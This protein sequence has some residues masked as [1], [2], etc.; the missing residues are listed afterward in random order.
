MAQPAQAIPSYTGTFKIKKGIEYKGSDFNLPDLP[1]NDFI[2]MISEYDVNVS[3]NRTIMFKA[4]TGYS[5]HTDDD[6]T[7]MFDRDCTIAVGTIF[8]VS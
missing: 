6:Y 8:L 2:Q 7:Y 4:T 3:I 1:V 5:N